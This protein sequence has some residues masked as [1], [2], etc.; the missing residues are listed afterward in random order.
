VLFS[1]PEVVGRMASFECAWQSV[2]PVP[3]VE[4]DFGDGRRLERTLHGNVA[5]FFC[6]SEGEVFDV[7]PGVSTPADYLARLERALALWP[8]VA[9]ARAG[10]GAELARDLTRRFH[11]EAALLASRPVAAAREAPAF[12]RDFAKLRVERPLEDA[13]RAAHLRDLDGREAAQRQDGSHVLAADTRYNREHRDP[14]VHRLLADR[15]LAPLELL[16]P[17]V[18]RD[19]LGV[20]LADPYLGLAPALLGPTAAR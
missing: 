16:G 20:D 11:G 9:E 17:A 19:V 14:L 18:Y 4:I 3:R 7:A 8:A 6:T 10:G 15:P 2:R 13:L 1:H 12:P 5:S